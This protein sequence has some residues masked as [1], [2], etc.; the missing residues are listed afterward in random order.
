MGEHG[1]LFVAGGLGDVFEGVGCATG[2][3]VG[4][5]GVKAR[6]RDVSEGLPR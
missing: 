6:R 4:F 2:F 5:G 3:A 1:G